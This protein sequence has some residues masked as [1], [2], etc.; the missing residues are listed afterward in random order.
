MTFNEKY[1]SFFDAVC[2]FMGGDWR[3]NKI[4]SHDCRIFLLSPSSKEYCLS[5]GMEKNK[6]RITGYADSKVFRSS[7]NA[8]SLSPTRSAEAIAEEIKKRIIFDMSDRVEQVRRCVNEETEKK[9]E[10]SL[11]KNL[12][13][14]FFSLS[15]YSGKWLYF[16]S[17]NNGIRGNIATHKKNEYS[18][19]IERLTADQLIKVSAFIRGL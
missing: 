6:F 10:K 14:K 8:C 16:V 19:N 17:E 9:G 11:I 7:F 1:S 18:L 12:L 4:K 3:V 15:S 13:N 2:V 5:I